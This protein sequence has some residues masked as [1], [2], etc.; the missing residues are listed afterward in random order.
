MRA[1]AASARAGLAL[2]CSTTSAPASA[3]RAAQ[4][5]PI[6]PEAA[7]DQRPPAPEVQKLRNRGAHSSPATRSS[8]RAIRAPALAAFS[9]TSSMVSGCWSG[10]PAAALVMAESPSTRIPA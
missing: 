10:P 7:G 1:A 6:P 9:S 4:A 3:S 5:A 2:A 8:S